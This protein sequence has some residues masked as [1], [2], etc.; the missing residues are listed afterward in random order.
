M[1]KEELISSLPI[2]QDKLTIRYWERDDLD[3]LA[4]WKSYPFPYEVF[5]F[6]FKNMSPK[7][8]DAH[9]RARKDN[10][11]RITLIIDIK[12]KRAIGYLS[13][14]AIDWE[15]MMVS[16]MGFRIE[17]SWCNKGIGKKS[18]EIAS[19]WCFENGFRILRFDVAASNEWAIRC[20]RGCGFI[21]A[22]DF[23]RDDM[24]LMD[25]DLNDPKY[26]FLR[27]HVRFNN[28]VP[29]LRFLW[30]ERANNG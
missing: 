16:N 11:K 4:L 29:Q 15:K 1:N 28:G 24:T 13:L 23:W 5:D 22:G 8:R 14:V 2:R 9:F 26:G 17:P 21:E 30:M 27:G 3:L 18:M 25:V 6:S 10:Q 20:Y 7:E 19:R 12:A